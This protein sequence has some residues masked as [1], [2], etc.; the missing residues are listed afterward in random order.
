MLPNKVVGKMEAEDEGGRG[1]E[2]E[3]GVIQLV[4]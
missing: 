3:D 1:R 2:D 4:A